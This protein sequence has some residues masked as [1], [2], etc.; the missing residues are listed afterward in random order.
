MRINEAADLCGLPKKTIKYYEEEELIHPKRNN[1]NNY[2]EYQDED[3]KTLKE[4]KLLR[5]LG[6]TIEDI[7]IILKNPED[8]KLLFENHIKELDTNIKNMNKTKEICINILVEND[9]SEGIDFANYL[10]NISN[11]EREGYQFMEENI[12]QR[13]FRRDSNLTIIFITVFVLVVITLGI[14][15]NNNIL[16]IIL[17]I[18]ITITVLGFLVLWHSKTTAYI[19]KQCDTKFN[20]TFLT[21]LVSPQVPPNKKYLKCPN[22]KKRVWARESYRD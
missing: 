3:I 19:C 5:K 16:G 6:F 15:L 22:C 12:K 14:F 21:D 8:L 11:M 20:I 7:R 9:Q 18:T 1:T 13:K 2:R 4:I 17:F 10:E